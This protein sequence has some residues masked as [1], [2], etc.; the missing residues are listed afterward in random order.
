LLVQ[1]GAV[2]AMYLRS[3]SDQQ[4]RWASKRLRPFGLRPKTRHAALLVVHLGSLNLTPRALPGAFRGSNAVS[5]IVLTGPSA[6]PPRAPAPRPDDVADRVPHRVRNPPAPDRA[7]PGR[8]PWLQPTAPAPAAA[9]AAGWRI[10]RNRQRRDRHA[11][12]HRACAT[13]TPVRRQAGGAE[14]GPG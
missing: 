3:M 10:V 12:R 13:A 9:T 14:F 5:R 4:R 11:A 8:R 6:R 2:S 1:Q 7:G